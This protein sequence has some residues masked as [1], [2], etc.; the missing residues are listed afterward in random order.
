MVQVHER[1]EESTDL[2]RRLRENQHPECVLC[3]NG[4]PLGLKLDLAVSDDGSVS[5][6]IDCAALF[7]G[8]P[9]QLHGGIIAL[10]I[11][12]AMTNCL[13][14]SGVTAVTAKLDIRYVKKT[15]TEIP[16]QLTARVTRSRGPLHIVE[17]D[18]R[19]NGLVVVRATGKFIERR[20]GI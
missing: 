1:A 4:D 7:Q 16:A 15:V 20:V 17:A 18:V 2:M 6:V 13:F 5:G 12:G 10:L 9:G 11:D 19:Q 3:G 8:Y 14:A